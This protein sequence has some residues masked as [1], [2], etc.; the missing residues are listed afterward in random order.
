MNH[1]TAIRNFANPGYTPTKGKIRI[2]DNRWY[3]C[4]FQNTEHDIGGG[5]YLAEGEYTQV[6]PGKKARDA[7]DSRLNHLNAIKE[8]DGPVWQLTSIEGY[9]TCYAS[10]AEAKAEHDRQVAKNAKDAQKAFAHL[11]KEINYTD[12]EMLAHY[13]LCKDWPG[14]ETAKIAE[15]RTY[16]AQLKADNEAYWAR[17]IVIIQIANMGGQKCSR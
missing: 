13:G 5:Y 9:I 7:R 10:E 14:N 2:F 6:L 11:N 8:Y 3:L 12:A 15:H 16:L 1:L 4:V 17:P